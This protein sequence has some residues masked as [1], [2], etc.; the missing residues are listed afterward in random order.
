MI[1]TWIG[2]TPSQLAGKIDRNLDK[3]METKGLVGVGIGLSKKDYRKCVIYLRTVSL[4]HIPE[5]AAAAHLILDTRQIV[6]V[7]Q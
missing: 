3:L 5:V 6:V 1:S 2:L 7:K 4:E